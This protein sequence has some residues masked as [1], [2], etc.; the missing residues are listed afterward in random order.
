MF[1]KLIE[2]PLIV[3]AAGIGAIQVMAALP[4]EQIVEL[5][6]Q[7]TI[8]IATLVRLFKKKKEQQP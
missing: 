6:V 7:I 3:G 4:V 8:G 1:S 2:S 5:V